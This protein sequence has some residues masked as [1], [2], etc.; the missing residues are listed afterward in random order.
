MAEDQRPISQGS[1]L[2]DPSSATLTIEEVQ[3]GIVPDHEYFAIVYEY[4]PEND[5]DLAAVQSQLDFLWRAGFNLAPTPLPD[6][7]KGS[8]LV[9]LSE[10]E[11]PWQ[12]GWSSAFY[13]RGPRTAERELRDTGTYCW[14]M[15]VTFPTQ[16]R[17]A[18]MEFAKKDGE[19]CR[20]DDR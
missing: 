5:N 7:W 6:N 9:D 15:P 10:I 11:C 18:A 17:K 12:L 16:G 19:G 3:R 20:E 2:R 13:S 4:V 14:R 8:V 1:R